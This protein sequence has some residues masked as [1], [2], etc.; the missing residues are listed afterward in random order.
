MNSL[1]MCIAKKGL[2]CTSFDTSTKESLKTMYNKL[3][4]LKLDIINLALES[5]KELV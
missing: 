3:W 1:N 4:K 2:V 5:K